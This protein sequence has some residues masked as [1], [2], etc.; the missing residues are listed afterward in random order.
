MSVRELLEVC[1]SECLKAYSRV[2]VEGVRVWRSE[3]WLPGSS[4]DIDVYVK[5]V[6]NPSFDE[7]PIITS[8]IDVLE[9]FKAR[10]YE[11]EPVSEPVSP[12]RDRARGLA[13]M[14]ERSLD[15]GR[16]VIVVVPSLLPV[17]LVST[18]RP[19]II[20]A[21]ES[22]LALEV[23]VRYENLLYLPE[24]GRGPITIVAKE[25]S[26]SSYERVEWLKK[27]AESLKVDVEG[28]V[29]K[30]DN[31]S[32]YEYVLQLGPRGIYKRVPVNKMALY[33]VSL[34]RC[35]N[36]EGIIEV[37][38]K[39]RS[40]HYIYAINVPESIIAGVEDALETRWAS[41][42]IPIPS[43]RLFNYIMEGCNSVMLDV[44]RRMGLE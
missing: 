22:S 1:A 27:Q 28:V 6:R 35:Y 7:V 41:T 37:N 5:S 11:Y 31:S 44:I 19:E 33:I 42:R 29:L 39:E 36:L 14:V 15:Q 3:E 17:S 40:R 12:G 43:E 25:N 26:E 20:D 2:R 30:P 13:G 34:A 24:E 16:G 32:I 9:G 4:S 23:E 38:R 8:I 18:L 10:I 21:M